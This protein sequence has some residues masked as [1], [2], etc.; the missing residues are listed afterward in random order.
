MS[1]YIKDFDEWNE[2]KK[3]ANSKTLEQEIWWASIG[4]NIGQEID[5]K[6]GNYERP[7]L[8][9]KKFSNDLLWALPISN[10][11]KDSDYFY[12]LHYKGKNRT[13][14]LLQLRLLSAN[15]LLRFMSRIE[16]GEFNA[17]I[18]RVIT[19]LRKNETPAFA[20]ESQ[21]T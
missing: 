19:L 10:T 4:V 14:L 11:R 13:I 7:V 12:P 2:I 9:L 15:R 5:G 3:A 8:I 17:I 6:N 20:E 18:D 16:E 21:Q 1:D